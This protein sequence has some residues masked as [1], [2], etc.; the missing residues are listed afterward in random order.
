MPDAVSH[1]WEWFWSLSGRRQQGYAGPQP[2]SY[3]EIDAWARRMR[4]QILPAE[5]HML[6]QMDNAYRQQMSEEMQGIRERNQAQK[7]QA[8]ARIATRRS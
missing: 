5:I 1:V 6:V 4:I 8:K 7:P 2:I 3:L